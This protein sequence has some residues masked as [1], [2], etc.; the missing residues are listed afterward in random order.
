MLREIDSFFSPEH[1]TN[2]ISP[3]PSGEN[4]LTTKS[5]H[6]GDHHFSDI[7]MM[8]EMLTMP[9]IAMETTMAFEKGI[10]NGFITYH[11]VEMVLEKYASMLGVP[12]D[13]SEKH[14]FGNTETAGKS[15]T[16]SLYPEEV[17]TLVFGIADKLLLSRNRQVHGFLRNFYAILFRLFDDENYHKKM[18]RRLVEYAMSSANNCSETSLD[19]LVFLVHKEFKVSR[20]VL[21]MIRDDFQLANSDCSA[22]QSTLCAREDEYSHAKEELQTELSKMTIEK[23]TLLERLH[24]SEAAIL[25]CKVLNIFCY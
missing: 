19:L 4:G 18:L 11:L 21:S 14:Q 13:S 5:L 6:A 25:H 23:L 24:E 1:L 22:L 9:S 16:A 8:L 10:A 2:G 12:V 17:F 3:L 15:C 20:L 7:F